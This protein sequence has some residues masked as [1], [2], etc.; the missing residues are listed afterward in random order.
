MATV[1]HTG[2]THIGFRQYG[3]EERREDFAK[4]FLQVVHI[5]LDEGVSAVI[6]AGD[7]FEDRTPGAEDLLATLQGLFTLKDAGIPFLG[8]VGN[9][10]QRRGT[11]WIDLFESLGLAVHLRPQRPFE[12]DGTP[13]YGMDFSGRRPITPPPCEGGVLVCHQ[14]LDAVEL[15]GELALDT[16]WHCGAQ[17]VLLGDYHEHREWRAGDKLVTYCGSTERWM[18]DEK[19]PRGVSIIDLQNGRLQRRELATRRFIYIPTDEDPI[20]RIENSDVQGAVVVVYVNAATPTA[21]QIEQAGYERG[22]LAV[23]VRDLRVRAEQ[24]AE[25]PVTLEFGDV[26]QAISEALAKK[27]LSQLAREIDQVIRDLTIADSNVDAEVTA[28]LERA[29]RENP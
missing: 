15:D 27:N 11:Q 1:L 4:A 17:F 19:K 22:A 28:L 5:A 26:E 23:R 13:I 24:P 20:Q 18:L 9:H 3:L 12:L 8:I 2:D 25:P 29:W 6:H 14:L 16:L 10:E 21:E 7:L